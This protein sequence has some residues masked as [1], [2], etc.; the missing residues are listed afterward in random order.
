[1]SK[2]DKTA[3]HGQAPWIRVGALLRL[4]RNNLI[5][6]I[7]YSVAIGILTLALPLATQTLVNT[8]AFGSLLQPIAV[9]S[10]LLFAFLLFSAILQTLREYVVEILQ[11]RIFVRSAS[12]A[13][14][15]L[16]RARSSAF[17]GI[18]PPELVNRFLEVVTVQK[19]A[20][21]LLVEGL[22]I[23][24]QTVIGMALLAVYHPYLGVF[25]FFLVI[26]ITIVLFPMGWGAVD[27]AVDESKAKYALVAWLQE[28]GR[29]L[30]TFKSGP[31]AQFALHRANELVSDYVEDR[32]KHFRILLRQIMG[33]LGLQVLASTALLGIG[34]YL[35]ITREL[36]LGQ[37]VASELVL[38]LAVSGFAKFGKHLETYYDL[39]AAVDKLGYLTDLHTETSGPDPVPVRDAGATVSVRGMSFSYPNKR[40]VFDG[41]DLEVRSGERVAIRGRSGNGKSTLVDVLWRLRTPQSGVVE[42]DGNDIRNYQVWSLRT[43]VALVRVHEVFHGSIVDNVAMGRPEIDTVQVREALAAVGLLE[44]IDRLQDGVLTEV[45]TFGLPLSSGQA[46]RLALARAIAGK[47]RLLIIDEVLDQVDDVSL[48]SVTL[49]FLFRD[50]APWTVIVTTEH[51]SILERCDTVYSLRDGKLEPEHAIRTESNSI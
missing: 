51:D 34:G 35:V 41:L 49:D 33:S 23:I 29:H 3:W 5:V 50:D 16:L 32:K 17:D 39:C 31:G 43:A 1:M 44:E 25:D 36:T 42:I 2:K 47:P 38:T 28:V 20:A 21:T 8:V 30:H 27:T 14:D 40:K 4:E 6:A 13:A 24:M 15:R 19:S 9:L 45:S 12:D 7:M 11:R 48:Q 18:H 22:T 37:L 10:I 46:L 26:A